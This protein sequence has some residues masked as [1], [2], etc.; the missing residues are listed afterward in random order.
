MNSNDQPV[1]LIEKIEYLTDKINQ[2]HRQV[3]QTEFFELKMRFIEFIDTSIER[4][5]ALNKG[6]DDP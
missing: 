3:K 5:Y 6:T 2:T 4:I 1:T